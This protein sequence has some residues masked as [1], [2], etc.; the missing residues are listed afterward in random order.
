MLE[1]LLATIFAHAD[2]AGGALT[3]VRTVSDGV[4]GTVTASLI[5]SKFEESFNEQPVV[6]LNFGDDGFSMP[7][8][9]MMGYVFFVPKDANA[10]NLVECWEMALNEGN[11]WKLGFPV[12]SGET[13]V[14]PIYMALLDGSKPGIT[15]AYDIIIRTDEDL[16]SGSLVTNWSSQGFS[17]VVTN[18]VP[19]VTRVRMNGTNVRVNDG[20]MDLH[21]F[22]GLSKT[23]TALTS[24]PSD[25]DLYADAPDYTDD[26]KAFTTEWSFDYGSGAPVVKYVYGPPSTP[27]TN[28][29]TQAGTCTVTVRMRDKDMDHASDEWGPE[30]TFTVIVD[31]WPSI[32][33]SPANGLNMFY[34]TD[35]GQSY[36]KLN[37]NLSMAPSAEITVH[38]DVTRA[39]ADDGNYPLPV[40]NTYD[41]AFNGSKTNA[42][43]WFTALDGTALGESQGY[44]ISAVVTNTTVNPDG[45]AWSNLYAGAVLPVTVINMDPEIMTRAGAN[46]IWKAENESFRIEYT[47]RD[48]PAD[49]THGLSV[50]WQTSEG[51]STNYTVTATSL[52]GMYTTYKGS[53]P[54]FAFTSAGSKT[55]TLLVEDKDGGFDQQQWNY[56]VP[57]TTIVDG[58]V[59]STVDGVLTSVELNGKADV[60]IPDIVTSIGDSAFFGCAGLTSVTIPN[61]VTSIGN[62]A[63]ESC[64]NLTSVMIPNSVTNIGGGAFGWCNSLTSVTIPDGVTS[65]QGNTFFSSGLTSV[66]IP[67]SVTNIGNWAFGWCT[68]L[69]RVAIPDG[70]TSIGW[71]AFCRC[72]GLTSVT[73]PDSV[74]SIGR[75]A[76]ADCIGL[77]NMIFKGNCPNIGSFAF[78][79]VW[80]S[81]VAYVRRDSTGWDVDIPGKWYPDVSISSRLDIQYLTP[82]VEVAVANETGSGTVEVDGELSAMEVASGVT[83]VV[84]GENLDAAAL[85]AKITPKPHEAGQSA[86]LFKVK[87]EAVVGGVSLAV[88]LDEDAVDPD[89]T[90]AEI[91]DAETVT[92]FGAAADGATVSVPLASAKQGLYY[93]IVAAG[94]LDGL[95]EAAANTPLVRAGGDGV[96]IPVVKPVGGAAFFK[97]IVSDRAR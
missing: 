4:L 69:T 92:V 28:A 46:E 87:A 97:V 76:F 82:E 37:L 3:A 95:N 88:V 29:F 34:E 71:G 64:T 50:T 94:N 60:A 5:Q 91:V 66:T 25:E 44:N 2:G 47:V 49:V 14:G 33:L 48:V 9:S 21:T 12:Y 86:S 79:D 63:F 36:G 38:L 77:T 75:E 11:D 31:D 89:E 70:V 40:L 51:F 65:I 58:V 54:M 39:G 80:D 41:I 42:F 73:I 53:S 16:D 85:A 43:V 52:G 81:C 59:F 8:G 7:D 6:T 35:V 78:S 57:V 27:L 74:T 32:S 68:N 22:P 15:M 18:V 72:R 55:V 17:F 23:F 67:N 83:L 84:K 93:G 1:I 10:S 26:L 13:E 45:V 56:C 30:F 96:T 90:A 24:E 61:S 19:E 20:T 62:D